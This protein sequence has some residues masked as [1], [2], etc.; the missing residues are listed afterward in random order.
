MLSIGVIGCGL[1]GP[2]LARNFASHQ[3]SRV[4]V[5]CDSEPNKAE[6]LATRLKGVDAVSDYR[7]VIDDPGVDAVVVATPLTTHYRI[8][9]D[10]LAAGKHVFAE[11]PL[12]SE[13]LTSR[14]LTELAGAS[15]KILMTGYVFL[16]NAGITLARELISSGSLGDVRYVHAVRTNLGPVRTDTSAVWDLASHDISV[17]LHCLGEVPSAVS[18]TGGR[19]LDNPPVDVASASMMFPS[20]RIGFVYVS[21][22]DPCKVRQITILGS[23]KMLLFDDMTPSEPIR[24]YDK[25]VERVEPY[26]SYGSHRMAVRPGDV[27]VPYVKMTEPLMTECDAF[28][29]AVLDGEPNPAMGDIPLTV[30]AVLEALDR[31]MEM[32]GAPAEVPV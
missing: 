29:R 13:Y 22:L 14:E 30:A 8:V 26:D 28:I 17:I 7:K 9:K 31:S 3:R 4:K 23:E 1:W 18:A 10:A 19:F 12:T 11:K 27:L 2:N 15:G 21:W 24:I 6:S 20:G 16:F 32:R 5:V 25:G